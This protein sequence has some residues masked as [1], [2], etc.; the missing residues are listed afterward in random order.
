M[1]NVKEQLIEFIE[2]YAAAKATSNSMLMKLSAS[3][4]KSFLD[5]LEV[6]FASPVPPNDDF[7]DAQSQEKEGEG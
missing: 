4:L 5:Q 3:S 6:K 1:E 7:G 2:A